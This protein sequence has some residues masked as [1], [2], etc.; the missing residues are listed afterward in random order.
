MSAS[1]RFDVIKFEDL[2]IEST[3]AKLGEGSFGCVYR[4]QYL[5]LPI[6]IKE[7][8][9][10]TDY[11][12]R[13]RPPHHAGRC[14]FLSDL[15]PS[16]S[17]SR[18][19]LPENARYQKTRDIPILCSTSDFAWPHPPWRPFQSACHK[20]KTKT[21]S[22]LAIRNRVLVMR[23]KHACSSSANMFVRSVLKYLCATL[24]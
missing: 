12:G 3:W 21:I 5:G 19:T 16:S 20:S 10:R 2:S 14:Q 13:S 7:I 11:D 24:Y 8:I 22:S 23:K 17:K 1:P 18:S 6:A 4:A 15:S 9:P